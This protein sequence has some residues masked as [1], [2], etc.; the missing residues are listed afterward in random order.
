MKKK[1]SIK[2]KDFPVGISFGLAS[3]SITTLGL[4]IGLYASTYSQGIVLAGI[5][6]I[7][8]TDAFSD[9]FAIHFSEEG[10]NMHTTKEIWISTILTFASKLIVG[11][12][13]LLAIIIFPLKIGII[14]N[15]FWSFLLIGV[16]S[17]LMAKNQQN[18]PCKVLLEH[19]LFMFIILALTYFLGKTIHTYLLPV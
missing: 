6:T 8:I 3:G 12:S 11:I 7:A 5:L 9:A 17:F 16:F 15:V 14:V 1:L 19:F 13:F 4:M 18:S 10:K 2:R